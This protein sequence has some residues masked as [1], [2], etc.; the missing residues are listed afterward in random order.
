MFEIFILSFVQGITEF[1]PV[2]SSSHLIIISKILNFK[3]Q[4]L[5][6]DV[7]LH[8][9]SFLAIIYYFK[10]DLILFY[11]KKIFFLL[12]L[13][14]S[15]PVI[16]IG[17]IIVK[18]NLIDK[19]RAIEIIGW[20]T[21][22]FGAILYISDRF[23]SKNTIRNNFNLKSALIIGFVQALALIPGVSRS[24]VVI[25]ISRFLGYN[26]IDAAKISFYLSIP[27]LAAVSLYGFYE[28]SKLPEFKI[29]QLNLISI[30]LSFLFSYITIKWFLMYLKKY[31]LNIFII[32]R[33]ILG[34]IIL[35][36]AYI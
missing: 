22:I 31:N 9:G 7:S 6:L 25:T 11:K 3:L 28:I 1:L 16:I 2:S 17:F 14:S 34:V 30:S 20:M 15:L 10:N 29:S 8:I 33:I 13:V 26:R 36:Y 4:S 12:I 23:K 24:G 18:L 21:I 5:L 19:I 35:T 32:Y 27:T